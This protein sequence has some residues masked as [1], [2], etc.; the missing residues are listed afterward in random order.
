MGIDSET[1]GA[2]YYIVKGSGYWVNTGKS[3]VFNDHQDGYKFF[4]TKGNNPTS[5][6]RVKQGYDTIQYLS[7]KDGWSCGDCCS[8]LSKQ[9]WN[10]EIVVCKQV[11][12][13]DCGGKDG[14]Q[15]AGLLKQGWMGSRDCQC[16]NGDN[17][18]HTNCAGRPK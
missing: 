10:Y 1:A 18:G 6:A 11:G 5:Q 13:F 17:G 4:K 3:K 2:W 9:T 8:K 12:K 14:S 15:E 16:K 7:H